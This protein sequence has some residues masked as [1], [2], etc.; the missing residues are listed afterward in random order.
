MMQRIMVHENRGSCVVPAGGG[1]TVCPAILV[2]MV[3]P[4]VS[5]ARYN[6]PSAPRASACGRT[7]V[8]TWGAH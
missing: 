4:N 6:R 5:P 3:L 1:M 8:V 2:A 7:R